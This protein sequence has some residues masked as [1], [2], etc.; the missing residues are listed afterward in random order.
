MENIF[1]SSIF[2]NGGLH[3]SVSG[4]SVEEVFKSICNTIK[5]PK[6]L[7]ANELYDA[8]CARESINTTAVGNG[9]AIPHSKTPIVADSED[10]QI[11]IC[12]LKEPLDMNAPDGRKV[13]V[14]FLILSSN[15]HFH[16]QM[17]VQLAALF[18]RSDFRKALEAHSDLKTLT[19]FIN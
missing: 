14:M 13:F 15:V 1:L 10:Q 17:I 18:K 11:A 2:E 12:Y 3:K 19:S 4:R 8:L 7:S 5:L 6:G 9:I 16:Q